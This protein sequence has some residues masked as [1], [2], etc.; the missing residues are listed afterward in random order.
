VRTCAIVTFGLAF[1]ACS[2]TAQETGVTSQAVTNASGDSGDPA[3]VALVRSNAVVCSGTLISPHVVLTAAHCGIDE[4]TF[5]QYQAYFGSSPASG[6]TFVTLSAAL[7]H[8]GFD[9]ST[10]AND[11]ALVVL[12]SD[13]STAPVPVLPS[14]S[15]SLAAGA[16]LRVVG[17]GSSGDGGGN[18]KRS[19]T[20]SVAGV[21]SNTIGLVPGPSLPCEG[22]SGGPGFFTVGSIEYLAGVT[23]DGDA[24]CASQA[25]DTRAD[26]YEASFIQPYLAS[27]A[28]GTAQPGARC[29]YPEQC[30]ASACAVAA[31]DPNLA[32]CAPACSTS[33]TC[34]PNTTCAPADGGS[35]CLYPLPTPG[36]IGS[37]CMRPSDCVGGQCISTGVCSERCVSGANDCPG[38]FD[39]EN[40]SGIDFYCVATP[41]PARSSGG[42]SCAVPASGEG[43]GAWWTFAGLLACVLVR[44]AT[45]AQRRRPAP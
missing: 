43:S 21:A 40:T 11:L 19:G 38:G 28:E 29:L 30:A 31:D 3:V 20:A 41:A 37:P 23:S 39:C 6:G 26:A 33:A 18:V 44:A 15:D 17:F 8:P 7:V 1:V 42:C 12:A 5:P 25:T 10:L 2:P 35:L 22:D 36:A 14:S 13:V 34:P 4:T 45:R 16:T 24:A 32:Y 27:I 9:S